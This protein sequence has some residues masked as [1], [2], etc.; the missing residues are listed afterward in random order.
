MARRY[1][2]ALATVYGPYLTEAIAGSGTWRSSPATTRSCISRAS[3]TCSRLW[4]TICACLRPRPRHPRTATRARRSRASGGSSG[5]W[6]GPARHS[7][8]TRGCATPSWPA[9]VCRRGERP[10]GGPARAGLDGRLR[11]PGR[12]GRGLG[13]YAD[14]ARC[15]ALSLALEADPVVASRRALSLAERLLE[16]IAQDAPGEL[17]LELPPTWLDDGS[18]TLAT[19]AIGL[20]RAPR[21]SSKA[22]RRRSAATTRRTCAT[23]ARC[24][25][26]SWRLGGGRGQR[27]EDARAARP[28]ARGRLQPARARLPRAGES[29]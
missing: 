26:R 21:R 14:G 8:P 4:R 22:F 15:D 9:R 16:L 24:S 11:R 18:G 17:Q 5:T 1:A 20:H 19:H 27:D 7:M 28:P 25:R 23:R 13:W 12:R 29:P 6:R 3:R 10:P 2:E